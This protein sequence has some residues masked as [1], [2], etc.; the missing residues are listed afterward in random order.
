MK[1]IICELPNASTDINGI[2]FEETM[3]GSVISVEAV[4]DDVA[5]QFANIPGYHL[6]D[7]EPEK[8][9]TDKKGK[10]ADTGEGAN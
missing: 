9:K 8:P 3:D 1:R 6:V 4:A 7:A 10:T 2:Q 5:N